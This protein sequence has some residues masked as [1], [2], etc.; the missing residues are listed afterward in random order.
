MAERPLWKA[1]LNRLEETL[2]VRVL[3]LTRSDGSRH[4]Y[5]RTRA[6]WCAL[7][8]RLGLVVETIPL[9]HHYYHPHVLFIARKECHAQVDR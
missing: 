4:F 9:D 8:G 2:A 3:R 7:L 5:F 6:E 1:W